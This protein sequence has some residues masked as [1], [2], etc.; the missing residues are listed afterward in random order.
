M[1][2][3]SKNTLYTPMKPGPDGGIVIGANQPASG[4]HFGAPNGKESPGIDEPWNFFGNTGMSYS[5]NGGVTVNPDGTL[6]FSNRWFVT[7]NGIPAI[8]MGGC[9]G[10]TCPGG[11]TVDTGKASISCGGT[12]KDGSSFTLQYSAHVPEGDPSGFGGVPYGLHMVGTVGMMSSAL[13]AGSGTL[14]PGPY[15]NSAGLTTERMTAAQL[16][17]ENVQPPT[18]MQRECVGGCFDFTLSGVSGSS[19]QVVL[20]LSAS[21]PAG[22]E[23]LKYV[24]GQWQNITKLGGRVDSAPYTAGSGS[25]PAPGSK[26]YLVSGTTTGRG[27]H[28][29]DNCLEVTLP[30]SGGTVSDPGGLAVPTSTTTTGSGPL[31]S[32]GSTGCSINP[33]PVAPGNGGAWLIVGGFIAWLGVA[34]RI[35]HRRPDRPA[36]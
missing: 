27:L 13:Q 5:K 21:V 11:V 4:S 32:S 14:T 17:N 33:E 30:V 24:G 22:A 23:Y 28:T 6:D 20:P 2:M 16:A 9:T 15:A 1:Q 26:A 29:G 35:R 19:A 7:W 3:S 34:K 10:S 18:G 8:N 36:R 25:C 31:P 12:C